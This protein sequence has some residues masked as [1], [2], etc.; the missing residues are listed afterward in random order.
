VTCASA[1]ARVV[2]WSHAFGG[3]EAEPPRM[4][5]ERISS[6][7]STKLVSNEDQHCIQCLDALD[8]VGAA[9]AHSPRWKTDVQQGVKNSAAT[10]V[11]VAR[12]VHALLG[13]DATTVGETVGQ[14]QETLSQGDQPM[15]AV[16]CAVL[17]AAKDLQDVVGG[18]GGIEAA[19]KMT[20]ATG[21]L[22]TAKERALEQ[23]A[24]AGA[25]ATAAGESVAPLDVDLAANMLQEVAPV[26][27]LIA[28]ACLAAL[29]VQ[30]KGKKKA[31]KTAAPGVTEFRDAINGLANAVVEAS[32]ALSAEAEKLRKVLHSC[33]K[34]VTSEIGSV[35]VQKFQAIVKKTVQSQQETC[36]Q[37]QV[38]AKAILE[39][40]QRLK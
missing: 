16:Q 38:T 30:K 15:A 20:T 21:L 25:N 6:V 27:L 7:D 17:D 31:N 36:T 26:I 5:L 40:V 11:Y 29:P 4:A 34:S 9:D 12:A 24:A 22:Q 19:T 35:D 37:L 18:E 3:A 2:V 10:K 39:F 33:G 23:L 1:A 28:S 13:G 14:L 8:E 32:R